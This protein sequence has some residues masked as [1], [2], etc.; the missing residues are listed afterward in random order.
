MGIINY[1]YFRFILINKLYG[2][3]KKKD[4]TIDFKPR[5]QIIRGDSTSGWVVDR[6]YVIDVTIATKKFKIKGKN[7]K[8]IFAQIKELADKN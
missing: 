2:A 3:Y 7:L 5:I 4:I 1:L 8:E 6:S